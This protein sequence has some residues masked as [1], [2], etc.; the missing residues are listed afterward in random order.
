[1]KRHI[2]F[3]LV[4]AI[5]AMICGVFYREFTKAYDFTGVTALGKL[6]THLFVLGMV[7][8]LLFALFDAKFDL[9][10]HKL[11]LPFMIIYNAGVGIMCVMLAVRGLFDVIGG[12]FSD[13]AIS[14]I[15]GLGHILVAAGVILF[16]CMLLLS[17]RSQDKKD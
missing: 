4:Y 16:F 7:M 3:A 6:H 12:T 17:L 5:L 8:F 13:G 14:G 15:A 1:M 10:K 9:Q 2:K 11:Y